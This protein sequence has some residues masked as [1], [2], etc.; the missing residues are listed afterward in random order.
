LRVE[1]CGL[2]VA[3]LRVEGCGFRSYGLDLV[4]IVDGGLEV[5]VDVFA[6]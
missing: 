1:G 3:D 2:R 5:R 4:D 6:I